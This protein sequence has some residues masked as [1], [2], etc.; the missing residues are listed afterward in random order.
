MSPVKRLSAYKPPLPRFADSS[1]GFTFD[2][3]TPLIHVKNDH[4]QLFFTTTHSSCCRSKYR[5]GG[6]CRDMLAR[7]SN[8]G[9]WVRRDDRGGQGPR[10]VAWVDVAIIAAIVLSIFRRNVALIVRHGTEHVL[11]EDSLLLLRLL[12]PLLVLS[13]ASNVIRRRYV[14]RIC[15]R[16]CSC[17]HPQCFLVRRV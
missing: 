15:L 12:R 6:S 1:P 4:R 2:R 16:R 8:L 9:N 10:N 13:S 14:T 5:R 17:Q 3:I 7:L 11:Y